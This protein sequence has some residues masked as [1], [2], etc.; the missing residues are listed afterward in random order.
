MAGHSAW[1]YFGKQK[2]EFQ[3]NYKLDDLEDSF[4]IAPN[5]GLGMAQTLISSTLSGKAVY[6]DSAMISLMLPW[7]ATNLPRVGHKLC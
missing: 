2:L 1:Y 5:T 7:K 6:S 4:E 3:H